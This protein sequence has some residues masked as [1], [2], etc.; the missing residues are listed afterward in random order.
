M[1]G[2][3]R[4]SLVLAAL[5]VSACGFTPLYEAGGS[6]DAMRTQLA[7]VEV[8]PIADRLGQIM[9]NQLTERLNEAG[10]PA[11]RLEVTLHQETEV[12]GFRPDAAATQEQLTMKAHVIFIS[13]K[14]GK[15]LFEDDLRARTAYDLVLSDFATVAQR[16]DSAKRLVLDLA[17]RIHRRLALY[18]SK[19]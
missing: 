7:S 14:D 12:Y 17:E 9:R 1:R 6:S 16:E 10:V 3:V 11:Y 4:I 19:G 5:L 2:A 15:K 8:A 13:L 18:F